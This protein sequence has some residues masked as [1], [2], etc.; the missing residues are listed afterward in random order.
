[1]QETGM[2]P[3][4]NLQGR[5]N[6]KRQQGKGSWKPKTMFN[7]RRAEELSVA[8]I[9]L[10]Q[11]QNGLAVAVD[12][13]IEGNDQLK[14]LLSQKNCT[15]HQLQRVQTKIEMGLKRRGNLKQIKKYCRRD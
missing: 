3:T 12:R 10:E 1:M 4:W 13:V 11:L 9:S 14:E 8:R 7:V 5:L 15:K 2:W 6:E